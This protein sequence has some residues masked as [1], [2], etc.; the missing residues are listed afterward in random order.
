MVEYYD[1][2]D[3]VSF[4][5][6][7]LLKEKGF[8]WECIGYYVDSEPNKL[9]YSFLGEVNSTWEPRCCSAPTFQMVMKWLRGVHKL[10][11]TI[12]PYLEEEP[13]LDE[14]IPNFKY[15]HYICKEN[16]FWD[17]A[18]PVTGFDTYEQAAEDAI[19]F[20]LEKLI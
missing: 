4:E 15:S 3:Y 16:E 19:L 12:S 10:H 6:A 20:C 11:I 9:Y 17:V 18:A 5:I 2:E 13:I 1:L 7:K 8:N 14:P